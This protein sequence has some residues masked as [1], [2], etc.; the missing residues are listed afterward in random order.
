MFFLIT[1]LPCK[2]L[3]FNTEGQIT[4]HCSSNHLE[5]PV[6]CTS[7]PLES[8]STMPLNN[9]ST[10]LIHLFMSV[11]EILTPP[12]DARGLALGPE[13]AHTAQ[14]VKYFIVIVS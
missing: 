13:P 4:M 8:S 5:Y 10:Y 1:L 14:K 11:I 9:V 2:W 6:Q 12:A 3:A 7:K